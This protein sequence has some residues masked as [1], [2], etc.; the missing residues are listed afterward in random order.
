MGWKYFVGLPEL[1]L[2]LPKPGAKA[3]G[4]L[5]PMADKFVIG[6]PDLLGYD[7]IVFALVLEDTS[8]LS[9]N[10]DLLLHQS[11]SVAH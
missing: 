6:C 4:I 10:G 7:S 3:V 11:V 5:T 2:F 1:C 8:H 9:T